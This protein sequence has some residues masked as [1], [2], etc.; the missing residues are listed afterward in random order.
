MFMVPSLSKSFLISS[1]NK[2]MVVAT[3]ALVEHL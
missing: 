2:F 3:K 1:V